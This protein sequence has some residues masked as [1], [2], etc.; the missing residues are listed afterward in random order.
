MTAS[1][2]DGRLLIRLYGKHRSL[3]NI[4]GRHTSEGFENENS[5]EASATIS[6]TLAQQLASFVVERE[7][8]VHPERFSDAAMYFA[9]QQQLVP[10]FVIALQAGLVG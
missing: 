10:H 9:R 6:E 1:I 2:E 3:K 4:F 5:P 8:E 7:A